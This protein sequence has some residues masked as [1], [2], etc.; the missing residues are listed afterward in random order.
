MPIAVIFTLTLLLLFTACKGSNTSTQ[1]APPVM[2]PPLV[3]AVQPTQQ[4]VLEW[5]EYT[6]RIEATETVTVKSRVNGYLVQVNFKAGD[7]VKKGD[8]L[9][10]I[11][12][13]P[14]QAEAARSEGELKRTETRLELARSELKRAVPLLKARAMS[15]EEYEIRDAAVR[16]ADAAVKT[17]AAAVQLAH[18]NL[19]FT[20]IRSP[21][22]GRVSR[23]LITVGNLVK[24]D[25]TL[26][27]VIVS[28]DPVYV[29]LDADE[30]AILKYRRMAESG[31]KGSG[32][33]RPV[34]AELALID[35]TGYPHQGHIDYSDPRL[36]AATG[37]L[38]VRGIFANP[39]DLLSPGF[40]ARV[41]IASGKPHAVVLVP[42][43]ALAIDQDQ[44][45]VWVLKDNDAVEYRRIVPGSKVGANRVI[46]EGLTTTDWVITEGLQKIRPGITVK[47][48]RLQTAAAG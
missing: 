43:R 15:Q 28:T 17:A 3:K 46:L 30:R 4:D 9:F 20:E 7:K 32:R 27:T 6:G 48:E 31:L 23:E 39:A 33:V 45:Y 21:I 25:D 2:P 47:P 8:L 14:Y 26:L 13:R 40:F 34:A 1:A 12:P 37:S 11:D 5:D 18:L 41:R 19:Q 10:V 36:D 29:Y 35:E 22:S 16:E 24:N 38:K 42:E 44:R